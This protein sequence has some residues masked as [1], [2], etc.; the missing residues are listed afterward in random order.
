MVVTISTDNKNS[1]NFDL[2]QSEVVFLL[3]Y[4]Q[5]HSEESSKTESLD[6]SF[7]PEKTAEEQPDGY[8]SERRKYKGFML[9]K[10]QECGETKGFCAKSPI[11]SY[12]CNSCGER[13]PLSNLRTLYQ[14]CDFCNHHS[15]YLTNLTDETVTHKCIS[16]E[17]ET[18]MVLN[19]RRTAYV[20][21]K[22]GKDA[23]R[24]MPY[25]SGYRRNIV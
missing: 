5:E 10:C 1:F 24:I 12:I 14:D 9:I 4:A 23:V 17:Q 11:D 22:T 13:T 7:R 25:R 8:V 19:S 16:C 2:K 15:K 3:N 18:T 20:T 21:R 6:Q